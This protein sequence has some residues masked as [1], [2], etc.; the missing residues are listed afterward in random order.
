MVYIV[1]T[2]NAA[3]EE[4]RAR[5]VR[6]EAAW[7]KVKVQVDYLQ[8]IAPVLDD[9]LYWNLEDLL[10]QFLVCLEKALRKLD[11]VRTRNSDGRYAL[12]RLNSRAKAEYVQKKGTLDELITDLEAW[13]TRFDPSWFLIIKIAS[14]VIDKELREAASS[15]EFGERPIKA[16]SNVAKDPLTAA[17]NLRSVLAPSGG[18]QKSMGLPECSLQTEDIRWSEARLGRLTGDSKWYLI[19]SISTEHAADVSALKRNIRQLAV[20]LSQADPL[21]FG[22]LSCKGVMPVRARDPRT[23]SPQDDIVAFHMVFRIPP[24]MDHLRSLRDL[25]I[26]S[27]YSL[28]VTQRVRTAH[29]LA[30]S[31]S[32][33]HTFGFVHKNVR[34]E[35]ILCFENTPAQR[36]HTFLV[37]F[38]AFRSADGATNYHGDLEWERNL[39]RHPLRQ[40]AYPADKYRMRHDIYSLGVCLLEL[41]LCESFV[42]YS[43]EGT[44]HIA[45]PAPGPWYDGFQTWL[46]ALP[47]VHMHEM[48]WKVKDYL[49]DLAASKLPARMGDKYTAIALGCLTCLDEEETSKSTKQDSTS[50]EGMAVA[51][52]FVEQTVVALTEI[53]T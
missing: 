26:S 5:V 38:D 21:A 51:V 36:S 27:P 11:A 25:L 9:T 52:Q 31:I 18:Q 16:P 41:G 33:V 1:K 17:L 28:S 43:F 4:V 44:S 22:L 7:G 14:P 20:K 23:G 13:Q 8:R 12:G 29:E 3:E 19:D 53:L 46:S 50:E 49:I 39:Y 40:G 10:Q 48:P 2:W 34:P 30:T 15:S 45:R 24:G 6:V 47:E 37:G 42:Q 35:A 32:Y